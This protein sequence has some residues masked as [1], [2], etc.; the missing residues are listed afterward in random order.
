[1]SAFYRADKPVCGKLDR[2]RQTSGETLMLHFDP[3]S[4]QV[5]A[6]PFPIYRRLREVSQ[7]LLSVV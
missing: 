6:D 1:M 4:P 5:D 2:N 3:F 7:F